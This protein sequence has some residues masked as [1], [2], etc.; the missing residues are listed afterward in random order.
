MAR[1]FYTRKVRAQSLNRSFYDKSLLSDEL[2]NA[3]VIPTKTPG[4]VEALERMMTTV[5]TQTYEGV[6]ENIPQPTL[7]IW[8][9]MDQTNLPADGTRLNREIKNSSLVYMPAS[10][11]YVQEEKP[12]ELAEA[13]KAFLTVSAK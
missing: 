9:E 1:Q 3:Y 5:A 13:I 10:G 12:D 2:I 6:A 7:I 11:H 8:G 4:A